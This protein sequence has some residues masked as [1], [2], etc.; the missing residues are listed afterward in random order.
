MKPLYRHDCDKCEFLGSFSYNGVV[1]D[2]S[3][4]CFIADLYVCPGGPH[5]D[6]T[7]IARLSDICSDY[8]SGYPSTYR[9]KVGKSI[10]ELSTHGPAI[11]EA[12]KRWSKNQ[13]T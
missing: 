13:T 4:E 5:S 3:V 6:D 11:A 7:L 9:D 2:D 8:C 1:T 10:S 12:Y